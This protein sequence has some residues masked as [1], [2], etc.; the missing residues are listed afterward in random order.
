MVSIHHKVID[1]IIIVQPLGKSHN[2]HNRNR[3]HAC[4]SEP[5]MRFLLSTGTLKV[6]NAASNYYWHNQ[7]AIRWGKET[8]LV[9]GCDLVWG[10]LLHMHRALNSSQLLKMNPE[11][12]CQE[13]SL[14]FIVAVV[15]IL[16]NELRALCRPGQCATTEQPFQ[17]TL[18]VILRQAGPELSSYP[19]L[20]SQGAGVMG[21][22]HYTQLLIIFKM[23]KKTKTPRFLQ[24]I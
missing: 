22:Q 12:N 13:N 15:T 9:C 6:T 17:L 4:Q 24:L 16:G 18:M 5:S 23:S 20:A 19:T 10:S 11:Y 2:L 1:C 3:W 7:P 8:V 14:N 21:Q